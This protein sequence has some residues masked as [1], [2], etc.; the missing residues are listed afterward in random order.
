MTAADGKPVLSYADAA[1]ALTINR[2]A[3]A[4]GTGVWTTTPLDTT[5]F[6]AC[7]AIY[8]GKVAVAYSPSTGPG[9]SCAILFE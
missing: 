7:V 3:T 5:G 1:E 8:A 9:L 4:D 2:C 6:A